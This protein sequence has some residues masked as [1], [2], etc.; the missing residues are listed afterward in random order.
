MT[1]RHILNHNS[2]GLHVYLIYRFNKDCYRKLL[3]VSAIDESPLGF[4]LEIMVSVF[5]SAGEMA[6]S[7][8]N[9][10]HYVQDIAVPVDLP[11][12]PDPG[13][14]CHCWKR[15]NKSYIVVATQWFTHASGSLQ[16]IGSAS[17]TSTFCLLMQWPPAPV[18]WS[19]CICSR[20]MDTIIMLRWKPSWPKQ[21]LAVFATFM[22]VPT[23]ISYCPRWHLFSGLTT[24]ICFNTS[25]VRMAGL[26]PDARLS[27][28]H[29][30]CGQCG[31]RP[32]PWP[33][34]PQPGA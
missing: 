17:T 7:H 2:T 18:I 15:S 22:P 23:T 31:V 8:V 11:I 20:T 6:V 29:R 10:P 5:P 14:F 32:V 16:Y 12:F 1:C 34:H 19:K 33:G 13:Y 26:M 21:C 3:F 4:V 28:V 9:V 24:Y 30:L 27:L 25:S